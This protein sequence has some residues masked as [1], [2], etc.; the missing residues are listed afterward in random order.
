MPVRDEL[1]DRLAS[2]DPLPNAERLTPDAHREADA[3]LARALATPVRPARRAAARGRGVRRGAFV[4]VGIACVAL[5]AFAAVDLVD[6]E[7]P[8]PSVVER[9]LAAVSHD[10]TV[11]HVLER[12]RLRAPSMS[13]PR[14]R[15]TVYVESWRTTDGRL[16][17]RLFLAARDG[18]RGRLFGDFAG[19]RTP[20]RRGGP[21]LT[22]S[23]RDNTIQ[24][25]RFGTTRGARGAPSLN[26]YADPGE[27]LRTF[28]AQGRLRVAG[29][30]DVDGTRA[31]RLVSGYVQSSPKLR[32]KVE[33][34]VDAETYLPL[35]SHSTQLATSGDRY[36]L[37]TR[38]LVY[39]RLRLDASSR[40]KLDLDR[41]PGATCAPG[42]G[43]IMG[44]GSLGFP[45]PCR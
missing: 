12:K 21:A 29:T 9:A 17:Q 35:A 20:G 38:Y 32:E 27:A 22:W 36:D 3:L 11:Y 26:P 43:A 28:E 44:R 40:A 24:S 25:I 33:F 18:E 31:Y 6:S 42:A 41:H 37:F 10:G 34:L 15:R 14:G 1:M 30:A 45:N 7:A 13:V 19:R 8:G 4:A 16:H 2:A 39:E 5:A 23:A